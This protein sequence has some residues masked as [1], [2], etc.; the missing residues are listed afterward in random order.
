LWVR[1]LYNELSDIWEWTPRAARCIYIRTGC[2]G[3]DNHDEKRIFNEAWD[4]LNGRFMHLRQ[5]CGG[6]AIIRRPLRATVRLLIGRNM[7]PTAARQVCPLQAL[8]SNIIKWKVD[9]YIFFFKKKQFSLTRAFSPF[10]HGT[11]IGHQQCSPKT[12][13]VS[14]NHIN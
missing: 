4:C 12:K 1:D 7:T 13:W 8:T 10:T 9:I 6:L 5:L 11:A 3:L 14:F 2:E